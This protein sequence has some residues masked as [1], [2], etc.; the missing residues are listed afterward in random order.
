MR[1]SNEGSRIIIRPTIAGAETWGAVISVIFPIFGVF[2]AVTVVKNT[3]IF[4]NGFSFMSVFPLVFIAVWLAMALSF[5]VSFWVS[6]TSSLILDAS[7]VHKKSALPFVRTVSIPWNS[8]YGWGREQS[9]GSD[10]GYRGFGYKSSAAMPKLFFV[11][12]SRQEKNGKIKT[13]SKTVKLPAAG[14][15]R[16]D[17]QIIAD[18]CGRYC[19]IKPDGLSL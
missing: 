10:S 3:D 17:Y 8:V 15:V 6:H 14:A 13:V 11:G 12:Q 19:S 5:S 9:Y 2:F 16:Q 4:E 1:I 7:G 18:Y